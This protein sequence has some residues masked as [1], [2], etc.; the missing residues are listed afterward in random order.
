M[1]PGG[2]LEDGVGAQNVNLPSLRLC[3]VA[4]PEDD[5][6][7]PAEAGISDNVQYP[8]RARLSIGQHGVRTSASWCGISEVISSLPNRLRRPVPLEGTQLDSRAPAAA[9]PRPRRP[10]QG[11]PPP[12]PPL[13]LRRRPAPR[14]APIARTQSRSN[15]RPA[16]TAVPES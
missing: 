2:L 14:L 8:D 1:L 13:P 6:G 9:S 15:P 12:Q 7:S 16:H 3:D 4:Q 10:A 5:A 11:A